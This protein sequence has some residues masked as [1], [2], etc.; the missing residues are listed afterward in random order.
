MSHLQ[1]LELIEQCS[2]AR[3]SIKVFPDLFEVMASGVNI[4]DLNGLP[5]ISVKDIALRGWNLAIK[6]GMDLFVSASCL[7]LLSPLLL[8]IALAVKITSPRGEVFYVQERVGLDGNPFLTY[9]FR[10]MKPDAESDTGPVWAS[11]DDQRRTPI[12]SFLRRFSLDEM[13]QLINVLL[14]EMSM[15]GPRP[16]RPV[17]VEQFRQTIPATS[18]VTRR[19]QVSPAGRRSMGCAAILPSRNVLPTTS[20]TWR[21]GLSGWTYEYCYAPCG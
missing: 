2:G 14:N 5:L 12:G 3:V 10:T 9:K 21:I 6:R 19:R 8:L 20:G 17:F 11:R 13:P 4:S 16:E 1:L 18:S 7:V 15:V